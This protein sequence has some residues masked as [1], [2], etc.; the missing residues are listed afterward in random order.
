LRGDDFVAIMPGFFGSTGDFW[1]KCVAELVGSIGTVMPVETRWLRNAVV[2]VGVVVLTACVPMVSDEPASDEAS[3]PS[4]TVFVPSEEDSSER[5]A[6][7]YYPPITS[8]ERYESRARILKDAGRDRRIGFVTAI[9]RQQ[10]TFGYPPQ[11]T[12]YAKGDEAEKLIIVALG[13]QSIA[14]IYQAC[15]LLAQLTAVA[16]ARE[17]FAELGVETYFTFFDLARMLGFSRLT[18]S[19]GKHF[20]HRVQIE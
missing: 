10:F 8:R 17:F 7:Y 5:H 4:A 15:A 19:D 6:G 11:Y 2:G 18:I 13:D 14:T 1:G 12:M 9:T 16:R 3:T 20:T